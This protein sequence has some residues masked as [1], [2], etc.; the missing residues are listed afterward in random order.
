M[1]RR[2][3]P[4]R[5]V[6]R[7]LAIALL[8]TIAL[9]LPLRWFAPL[10]TTFMVIT[11]FTKPDGSGRMRYDWADRTAISGNAAASVLAAE[12]QKFFSHAGFDF[13]AIGEVL[14]KRQSQRRLRGASTISQQVVKNLFLW[15]GRSWLR[16]GIEAWLTVW[17][18]LLLPKQRILE[19]HLN[20]AQFGPTVFGVEAASRLYFGKAAARLNRHEAALLAAVLPNPARLSVARPSSYV[21]RR[22]AWIVS[23]AGRLERA[24]LFS[25]AQWSRP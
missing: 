5:L 25:P 23:Q 14:T 10:T 11:W 7:V 9:V 2:R 22:Q 1:A 12:D 8:G 19:L 15:P 24:G 16:K 4:A 13:T 21:R 20:I 6:F 3:R 18:E 17:L